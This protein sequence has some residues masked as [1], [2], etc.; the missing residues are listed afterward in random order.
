VAKKPPPRP[1]KSGAA[2][3]PAPKPPAK[4]SVKPPAKPRPH[5][6]SPLLTVSLEGIEVRHN[7]WPSEL[8]KESDLSLVFQIEN[9]GG[10]GDNA[11]LATARLP[12]RAVPGAT[13]MYEQLS[14]EANGRPV[15]G[16]AV[17]VA[18]HVN[19]H[20]RYF[21]ERTNAL[22][23]IVGAALNTVVE[24]LTGRIP[25]LPEPLREA[26]H[27]QIGKTI[28]TEL[29]RATVIVPV[30]ASNAGSHGVTVALISPRTIMGM[31]VPPG[32]PEPFK[33]GVIATEGELA[34][35]LHLTIDVKLP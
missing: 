3:R 21:I 35:I 1:G 30:D 9:P 14:P 27:I 31:Y 25:L 4:P 18:D 12:F 15:F 7:G 22:G 5:P 16:G 28:A 17:P 8:R 11:V 10:A 6:G 24:G 13:V 33:K 34:A 26:L 32:S 2:K 20:V 23:P 19:L 29:A